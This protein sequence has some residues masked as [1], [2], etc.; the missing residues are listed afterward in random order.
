MSD[1]NGVVK[2]NFAQAW[3][4]NAEAM[5]VEFPSGLQAEMTR[6]SVMSLMTSDNNEIPDAFFNLL[7]EA[8]QT[9]K[10]PTMGMK[11]EELREF[12]KFMDML[13]V[14]L[15]VKHFTNPS[16]VMEGKAGED[17]IELKHI[18]AMDPRDKQFLTNWG[19]NGGDHV[20][21]LKRFR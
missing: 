19:M 3:K 11:A 15:A 20:D 14:Q 4:K 6:P 5:L 8:Q 17:Q 7:I 18:K 16:V 9:G 10:N 2:P 1:N 13:A 12:M 21:L